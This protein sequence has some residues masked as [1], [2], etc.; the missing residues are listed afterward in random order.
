M[1]GLE[2]FE[3]YPSSQ[4]PFAAFQCGWRDRGL[5]LLVSAPVDERGALI[6]WLVRV[7]TGCV[8]G[9]DGTLRIERTFPLSRYFRNS[10]FLS[11]WEAYDTAA[12]KKDQRV[13]RSEGRGK[14][15]ETEAEGKHVPYCRGKARKQ[16]DAQTAGARDV[17]SDG[18][19]CGGGGARCG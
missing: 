4:R 12:R 11:V 17:E 8:E 5:D 16:K 3:L 2:T 13:T 10:S 19:R 15:C 18:R 9:D 7:S 1:V 14:R 6:R